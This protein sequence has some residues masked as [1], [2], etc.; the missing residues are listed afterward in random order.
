MIGSKRYKRHTNVCLANN[1]SLEILSAN[2]ARY[3]CQIKLEG[4]LT[5][6]DAAIPNALFWAKFC[7]NHCAIPLLFTKNT[8]CS[9]GAKGCSDNQYVTTSNKDSSLLAWITAIPLLRVED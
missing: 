1:C 4:S 8:S 6:K 5:S 3:T 9:K 2:T 7:F